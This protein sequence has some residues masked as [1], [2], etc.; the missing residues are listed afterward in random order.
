MKKIMYTLWTILFFTFHLSA[1]T[2]ECVLIIQ[3]DKD[4]PTEDFNTTT[5]ALV[6]GFASFPGPP[7][8][9]VLRPMGETSGLGATP[10]RTEQTYNT[11]ENLL[12]SI[13]AAL[14]NANCKNV[15]IAFNGHGMGGVGIS[16]P[17]PNKNAG[18]IMIAD[19]NPATFL[20]AS[21]VAKLI[22]ECQKSVKLLAGQCYGESMINGIIENLTNKHLAGVGGASSKWDE[23]SKALVFPGGKEFLEWYKFFLEDY[24]LI[25][26]NPNIMEK[27]RKNAEDLK[28]KNEETNAKIMAENAALAKKISDCE[29][30]LA[31]LKKQKADTEKAIADEQKKKEDAEKAVELL[32]ERIQLEQ[33]IATE[34]DSKKLR[35]L[36]KKFNANTTALKKMKIPYP[37]SGSLQ[38]KIDK[39]NAEIDKQ[40]MAAQAAQDMIDALNAQWMMLN[41]KITQKEF[42]LD[43]L[44]AMKPKALIPDRLPLMELVIHEALKSAKS[45]TKE[46]HPTQPVVPDT[47]GTVDT[48][49]TSPTKVKI[50]DNYFVFYKTIDKKTNKCV[51]VGYRQSKEGFPIGPITTK[52]CNIDCSMIKFTFKENGMDKEVEATRTATNPPTYQYK[53]DGQLVANVRPGHHRQHLIASG[54]VLAET[55]FQVLFNTIPDVQVPGWN[56]TQ[57]NFDPNVPVLNF[58]IDNGF[59]QHQVVFEFLDHE[60]VMISIDQHP[61]YLGSQTRMFTMLDQT[62]APAGKLGVIESENGLTGNVLSCRNDLPIPINGEFAADEHRYLLFP[63]FPLPFMVQPMPGNNSLM[64]WNLGTSGG[65]LQPDSQNEPEV[66]NVQVVNPNV[67]NKQLIWN[68]NEAYLSDQEQELVIGVDIIATNQMG[69]RQIHHLPKGQNTFVDPMPSAPGFINYQVVTV[70]EN[71]L[72]CVPYESPFFNEYSLPVCLTSLP[73]STRIA[74][75]E[76]DFAADLNVVVFPNPF[77]SSTEIRFN[78]ENAGEVSLSIFSATGQLV[79]KAEGSYFKGVNSI[80]VKNEELSGQGIYLFSLKTPD[81]VQTGKIWLLK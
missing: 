54:Q 68:Y 46:S 34:K 7:S 6:S 57:S 19:G 38:S 23:E 30:E 59:S 43:D 11:K 9:T 69:D 73:P 3:G 47:V 33:D 37:T 35:E 15:V 74:A 28:K 78:L 49:P 40:N 20:L 48:I 70:L 71:V 8:I 55:Y 1:Q 51:V 65:I 26:G 79:K 36:R 39:M 10:A 18:G 27:L 58:T 76:N 56:V 32:E 67:P 25:I 72:Y 16:Q 45:K 75:G 24:Y 12:A 22:D 64:I 5:D 4:S 17:P 21:D 52:D 62:M 81:G 77:S 31:D 13:K 2:G 53:V 63:D 42:D 41:G 61:P 14:C 66:N 80:T 44:K 29:A 60:D 50:G